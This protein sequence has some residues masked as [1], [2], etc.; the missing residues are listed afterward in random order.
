[1]DKLDQ[2]IT[3][4][5]ENTEP[6]T[7]EDCGRRTPALVEYRVYDGEKGERMWLCFK[8]RQARQLDGQRVDLV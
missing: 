1:M 5:E 2:W 8:C 3:R 6:D 7:C 4:E